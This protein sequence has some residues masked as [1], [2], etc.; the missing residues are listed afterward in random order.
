[1]FKSKKIVSSAIKWFY[2]Q[3]NLVL[4]EVNFNTILDPSIFVRLKLLSFASCIFMVKVKIAIKIQLKNN[5]NRFQNI[6]NKI[7][8][9]MTNIWNGR[10]NQC[11]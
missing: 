1:M 2:T 10:E 7:I 5:N 8:D 6:I 4:I 3:N 11:L 9:D